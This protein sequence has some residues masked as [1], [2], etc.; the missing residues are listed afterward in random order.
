[1]RLA[2]VLALG[3]AVLSGQAAG[4]QEQKLLLRG[5]GATFPAPLYKKWIAEYARVEPKTA[6]DY[7]EVG[8]GEGTKRFLERA[9][10]FGASDA[11][12][13]DEQLA[14]ARDAKLVPTTAGMIALVYNLPG[15]AG[16]LKLPRAV[17]PEILAGR[18][19]KWNDARIQAANPGLNLPNREIALAVRLDASGTTFNLTNHLNAISETWRQPSLGV[20]NLVAWEGLALLARGNEGVAAA[21]QR[22]H[23]TL[24]YVEYGYAKRLGL[25]IALLE[26]KSGRYV[27]PSAA[28]GAAAIAAN[29]NE[30]PANLRVYLPDPAGDDSYPIVSLTWLLVRERHPEPAKAEALK[31]FV[32]WALTTGQPYGAELGFV[33]LPPGLV[34]RARAVARTIQ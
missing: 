26:N 17:Y 27:A 1:M 29:L 28:S 2:T 12:L 9:V 23:W 11:G 7:K 16:P 25:A 4:Q 18:I 8:S 10:D 22:S 13:S 33:P 3:L 5:A 34:E 30:V 15:L 24:G 19:A 21:V 32:E 6:I 20:R 14:R 31:R